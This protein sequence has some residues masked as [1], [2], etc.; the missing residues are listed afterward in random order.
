[1]TCIRDIVDPAQLEREFRA[2]RTVF[3]GLGENEKPL[4]IEWGT[5]Q[6]FE[7]AAGPKKFVVAFEYHVNF[8]RY[9]RVEVDGEITKFFDDKLEVFRYCHREGWA[10]TFPSRIALEIVEAENEMDAQM[11]VIK[12]WPYHIVMLT[13]LELARGS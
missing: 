11:K 3:E 6:A 12:K 5:K 1:M 9:D 13:A 7:S 2:I 8:P 10:T 4:R